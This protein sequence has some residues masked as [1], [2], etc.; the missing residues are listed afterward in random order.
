MC[1]ETP[2]E[3]DKV[4]RYS[5]VRYIYIVC[6]DQNRSGKNNGIITAQLARWSFSQNRRDERIAL[7]LEELLRK[8]EA[9][10]VGRETRR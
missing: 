8:S 7:V 1:I 5:T 4:H 10:S 9:L 3:T 2:I 6:G